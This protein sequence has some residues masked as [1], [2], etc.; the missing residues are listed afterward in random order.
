[1]SKPMAHF[2]HDYDPLHPLQCRRLRDGKAKLRLP[3]AHIAK[4]QASVFRMRY[5]ARWAA[6]RG[7]GGVEG[8]ESDVGERGS[9]GD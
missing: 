4:G 3:E 1:M 7:D 8:G 5:H 2:S 6:F 9:R